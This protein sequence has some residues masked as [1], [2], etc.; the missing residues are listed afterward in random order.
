MASQNVNN[1]QLFA[2]SKATASMDAKLFMYRSFPY[3]AMKQLWSCK[4]QWS[5]W[6]KNLKDLKDKVCMWFRNEITMIRIMSINI[7]VLRLRSADRESSLMLRLGAALDFW[8][9]AF[10]F[11]SYPLIVSFLSN[12]PSTVFPPRARTR[13][14]LCVSAKLTSIIL[15]RS[16]SLAAS[17]AASDLTVWESIKLL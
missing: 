3:H 2:W 17:V 7:R 5:S 15:R 10:Q 1:S 6:K 4:T 16:K 8:F 13:Q 9:R 11:P 14:M 12:N